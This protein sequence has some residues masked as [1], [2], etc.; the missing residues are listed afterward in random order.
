MKIS[1]SILNLDFRKLEQEIKRIESGC[2]DSFHMDIMDGHL[3]DNISFGPDIVKTV[4]R[5][6]NLP[7]QSH[8]MI[9]NPEKFTDK[10]FEV[11]SAS[12]TV[13]AEVI[14]NK[15]KNIFKKDNMGISL[16][17]DYKVEKIFPHLADVKRVLV[18]SVYAGFGGQ[19]FIEKSIDRILKISEERRRQNLDFQISVDGGIN[20][21]TARACKSA[22][23]DEVA[24]GS[25]ITRSKNPVDRIKAIK[26]L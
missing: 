23:A 1:V 22:G 14:D 26:K 6:T 18:M 17:P 8:L 4:D 11:G 21:D 2:P 24:V 13:H 25:Y 3:V 7:L 15:N 16:D 20:L 10:F 12:V 19:I 9:T 5:I